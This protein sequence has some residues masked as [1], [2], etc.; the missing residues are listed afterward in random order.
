MPS[1]A[2]NLLEQDFAAERP[3]ERGCGPS[4]ILTREGGLLGGLMDSTPARGGWAVRDRCPRAVAHRC[5]EPSSCE[6]LEPGLL[7]HRPRQSIL[8]Y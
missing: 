8:L 7:H 1:S 3:D 6:D 5:D 4:Y 2:P